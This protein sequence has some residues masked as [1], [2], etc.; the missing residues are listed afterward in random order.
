MNIL[1][2]RTAQFRARKLRLQQAMGGKCVLCGNQAFLQF[3]CVRPMGSDHHKIGSLSR[4]RFYELQNDRGNQQLLC[5]A[6]HVKKS[7]AERRGRGLVW[8]Y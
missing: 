6:C 5:P 7:I 8:M 3:D 2:A 4:I 1:S